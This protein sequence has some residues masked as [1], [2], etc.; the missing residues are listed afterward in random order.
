M[1]DRNFFKKIL[2]EKTLMGMLVMMIAV[3]SL[4][5]E[6]DTWWSLRAGQDI[7]NGENI[8]IERWTWTSAGNFWENHETAWEVM[9]YFLYLLSGKT[10][11]LIT[12]FVAFSLATPVFLFLKEFPSKATSVFKR[13][14]VYSGVIFLSLLTFHYFSQARAFTFSLSLCG[15]LI[16]LLREKKNYF[17]PL[18]II[19]WVNTHGSFILGCVIIFIAFLLRFTE[20]IVFR[21]LEATAQAK[22]IFVAG[23][24]SFI[25][26]FLNPLHYKIWVYLWNSVKNRDSY[27]TEWQS[28][29]TNSG[30]VIVVLSIATVFTALL[31]ISRPSITWDFV[32]TLSAA[33]FLF[34][35]TF[36][37]SRA[38][39]YLYVPLLFLLPYSFNVTLQSEEEKKPNDRQMGRAVISGV[40]GSLVVLLSSFTFLVTKAQT[41]P[42]NEDALKA[43]NSCKGNQWNDFR[44]GGPLIWFNKNH[45][46]F[47]DNRFDYMNDNLKK[48]ILLEVSS[49]WESFLESYSISCIFVDKSEA[50]FIA[51]QHAPER[52]WRVAYEDNKFIQYVK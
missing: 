13:I 50:N 11:Y 14:C 34:T 8:F 45:K 20:A 43:Y 27:I 41:S 7:L 17:L 30:V 48:H 40:M 22:Q 1:D 26:T 52:G 32:I 28:I 12:V 47:Q 15:V 35:L 29:T 18:V 3:I 2:T 9:I 44:T 51:L 33:V 36:I 6:S 39:V 4:T 49:D 10:Y 31:I 37:M 38:L 42:I 25:A 16:Y 21:R 5:Y 24:I 19:L 23:V 46:V